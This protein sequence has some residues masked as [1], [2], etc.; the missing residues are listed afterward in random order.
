MNKYGHHGSLTPSN[1]RVTVQ[2]STCTGC[3]LCV[4]RCPM[5]A[6]HLTDAPA[7]K[8]RKTTVTGKDGRQRELTNK[9]G[10]VAELNPERCIGCG[11]CAYK[12]QSQSLTLARNQVDHHPPQTGRDWVTQF[13]AD[14]RG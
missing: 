7:V 5:G 13:I 10:K 2:Q 8:G 3:G 6:L 4:K 9:A 11:V 12:C 14:T 1:F